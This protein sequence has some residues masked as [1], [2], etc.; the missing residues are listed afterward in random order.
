ML[1]PVA[2][3]LDC[4]AHLSSDEVFTPPTLAN[5][6]LDLLPDGVWADPD[7]RWLDPGCKSGVFLREA[8][9]RLMDGLQ[10]LIRDE[11]ERR[12][13]VHRNMLYGIA[14]TELTALASR[15]TL[16]HCRFANLEY[17][18]VQ[19]ADEQGNIR[20][21]DATH[22]WKGGRCSKC[23]ASQQWARQSG[24]E[25]HAYPFLHLDIG[26]IFEDDDMHFDVVMGN[27]PYQLDDGGHGRSARPVYHRFVEA[28]KALKP[29][30]I[31]YVLP[32]R[33]YSGG[34]GLD[35]FRTTMLAD[36]RLSHLVDY[37]EMTA[38]FDGVDIAG[39]G[40][41]FLWNADHD[42]DC[43]V[44]PE[45]DWDRAEWRRLDSLEVFIRDHESM[46][47][48]AKVL[49]VVNGNLGSLSSSVWARNPF[50]MPA[51]LVP[52]SAT[53]EPTAGNTVRLMT[54]EGDRFIRSDEI[55]KNR[56][57]LG[58]W[59]V[60]I[61]YTCAEHAGNPD[62][63]GRKRVLSR[64]RVLPPHS[65]CTETYLVVGTFPDEERAT[66]HL[67]YLR[68]KFARFLLSLM[69]STQHITRRCFTF[70][71]AM[72]DD[73]TWTDRDLYDYFELDDGEI[74]H[75]EN[76]IKEMSP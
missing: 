33:W 4:L 16:Y 22:E 27:P 3:I 63:S 57:A 24:R 54:R 52:S 45:G 34:K 55:R 35:S 58:V 38:L 29:Q 51:H 15:R 59:K 6:M 1:R 53:K 71:P 40:C 19:F 42:G 50:G 7:L 20:F 75:I 18:I 62:K 68:T 44:A 39:G 26:E 23:G 49:E 76:R 12:E 37:P 11:D 61:S 32:A 73:R 30:Y 31:T 8:E 48:L 13:H 10:P 9:R 66:N 25:T 21:P 72:P 2:D 56:D 67:L 70:V 74:S 43:L 60:V 17:S 41:Y 65:A 46:A 14:I 69:V 5:Q 64:S 36:R 28:A 47:V